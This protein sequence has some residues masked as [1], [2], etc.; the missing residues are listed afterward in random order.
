MRQRD[1]VLNYIKENG[2][3]TSLEA[4][5]ELGCTRLSA[6]V[7]RLRN[8]GYDFDRTFVTRKNRWNEKVSFVKYT[9]KEDKDGNAV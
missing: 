9:L 6:E 8:D 5:M 3:I 1:R 7:Y 2:S 4:F